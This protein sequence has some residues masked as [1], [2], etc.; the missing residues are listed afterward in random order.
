MN[1]L[2]FYLKNKRK[3]VKSGKNW[4]F[5]SLTIPEIS[6]LILYESVE[7]ILTNN[8]KMRRVT[9]ESVARLLIDEQK[10]YRVSVCLE[11]RDRLDE[12]R[13]FMIKTRT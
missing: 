4:S 5:T 9:A 2:I 8:L 1:G 7:S 12:D 13:D 10:G 3:H 11:L 6:E